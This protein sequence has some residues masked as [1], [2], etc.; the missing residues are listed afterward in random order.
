M[1]TKDLIA[2]VNAAKFFFNI[3]KKIR[4]NKYI[5]KN[6]WSRHFNLK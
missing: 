6:Y 4:S 5:M 3:Y 2:C 1:H